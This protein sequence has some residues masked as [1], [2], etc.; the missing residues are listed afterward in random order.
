MD[1]MDDHWGP[2]QEPQRF[3]EQS[4]VNLNPFKGPGFVELSK[5]LR[6][7]QAEPSESQLPRALEDAAVNWALLGAK[8][9]SYT[10]S[11]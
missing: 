10:I 3:L 8:D 5:V 4:R 11:N 1:Q 9:V 7:I 2:S 6:L